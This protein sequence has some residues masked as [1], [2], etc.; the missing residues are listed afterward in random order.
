[1]KIAIPMNNDHIA[2]HFTK[3]HSLLLCDDTGAPLE[4]LANPAQDANCVI[5]SYSIHYTKLYDCLPVFCI[6]LFPGFRFIFR[7]HSICTA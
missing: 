5:T 1:M 7:N 6:V 2:G 3:A 4:Q